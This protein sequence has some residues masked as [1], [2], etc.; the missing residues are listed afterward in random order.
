MM[1]IAL[2]QAQRFYGFSEATLAAFAHADIP[3]A[4]QALFLLQLTELLA[5]RLLGGLAARVP[6]DRPLN[7]A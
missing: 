5:A 6:A 7:R 2:S 1:R 4:A 3:Y